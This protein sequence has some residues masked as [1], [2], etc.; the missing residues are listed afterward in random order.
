[1]PTLADYRQFIIFLDID[2]TLVA[3]SGTIPDQTGIEM[4]EKLKVN[5]TV[6]LC[7]NKKN[8]QERNRNLAAYL[9]VRYLETNHKK[10]SRK[11][12]ESVEN[13]SNQSLLVIGDK[14]ITDG[15]FARSINAEFFK[16][17]HVSDHNES[18]WV[19]II[20]AIDDGLYF[21]LRR[22]S[23]FVRLIRLRQW[24]K[25]LLV[26][27]PVI[28]ARELFIKDKLL[29][30]AIAFLLF[31]VTA[32]SMYIM[33]DLIDRAD[34]QK[35]PKK[36]L[37]PVASGEI[38]TVWS[39]IILTLLGLVAV[40]IVYVQPVLLS[41]LLG[42][43]VANILYSYW[44]KTLPIFDLVVFPVFYLLRVAAG[45]AAAQTHL[46]GW[47]LL[48]VIFLSLFIVIGKR[49]AELVH[50]YK[51]KVLEYYSVFFLE[52]LLIISATLTI[53]AY[54]IYTV[55]GTNSSYMVFSVW[56]VIIGMF[57]YLYL[58]NFASNT[59]FPEQVILSDKV[60]LFSGAGWLIFSYFIFYLL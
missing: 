41:V 59:E 12:L 48:C 32:S 49:K 24:I 28:F 54:S 33:N 40:A 45:G 7:S 17:Q 27:V 8:F 37:R 39:V 2:G 44:L 25:N 3:D 18:I 36:K 29:A 11:I 46:S 58:V 51:R 14:Y 26:F 55:L 56:F 5:N 15:L 30:S 31:S 47:L 60:I 13:P 9:N 19:K 23:I 10:P 20:Y 16:V 43:I 53:A 6:Y 38:T 42:Y 4:V 35:H 21:L 34:D 50:E 22:L 52:Q 1:M 57:R